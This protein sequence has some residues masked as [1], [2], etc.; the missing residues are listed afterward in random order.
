MIMMEMTDFT[1]Y[2][3]RML[4]LVRKHRQPGVPGTDSGF[5]SWAFSVFPFCG[6]CHS[7]AA[8]KKRSDIEWVSVTLV[9]VQQLFFHSFK[10]KTEQIHYTFQTKHF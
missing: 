3:I 10:P 4:F 5:L 2:E 9:D 1:R 8:E 7:L 6:A